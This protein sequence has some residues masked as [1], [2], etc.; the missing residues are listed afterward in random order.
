LLEHLTENLLELQ[1]GFVYN[2]DKWHLV[3]IGVKGDFPFQ[4]KTGGLNRHW[5]R[6]ARKKNASSG[7]G[8]CWLCMGGNDAGGPWED[9]NVNA[10]WSTVQPQEPWAS[11]PTLLRLFHNVSEPEAFFRPDIWHCYHGGAGK[12]F[13]AS[14]L[15]EALAL[16]DGSMDNRVEQM[17]EALRTWAK[18][19][20]NQLP[21]SG[22]FCKERIQLTSYQV[23]PDASWSKFNDTYVYHR[24]L[25]WLLMENL[26]QVSDNETLKT[27]LDATRCINRSFKILYQ[28]GL[29]LTSAEALEA[30]QLG[31][32]FLRLYVH[33]AYSFY[34]K[35]QL[36]F[37]LVVKHHLLDH[38][39]RRLIAGSKTEYSLNCLLD[40]VQMDEDFIGHCARLSRRV[41]PVTTALRVLQRYCVRAKKTW[42]KDVKD[43]S[44]S[45]EP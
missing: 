31:R 16:F 17:A 41:S 15:A 2:N 36:R 25:E 42:T 21:H 43:I 1:R 24:F 6:A 5:L 3:C 18:K 30:G 33:L 23:L 34:E 40:S 39:Y 29:F 10:R 28:S 9:F 19:P 44:T 26:E 12:L 38:I 13:V 22:Q 7:A 45:K 14:A 20:G 11:R 37:P 27:I 35:K 8:V 4:I 32:T